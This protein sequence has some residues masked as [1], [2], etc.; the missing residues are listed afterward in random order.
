MQVTWR[1]VIDSPIPA[2]CLSLVAGRFG[3]YVDPASPLFTHYYLSQPASPHDPP[4]SA[5]A[6]KS[7]INNSAGGTAPA[8][9]FVAEYFSLVS[10]PEHRVVYVKVIPVTNYYHTHRSAGTYPALHFI[11]LSLTAA[12]CLPHRLCGC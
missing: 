3:R 10:P 11:T 4:V 9:Q 8:V 6:I 5:S 7:C 2:K 12:P 1:Y